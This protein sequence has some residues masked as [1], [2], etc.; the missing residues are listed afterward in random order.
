MGLSSNRRHPRSERRPNF[1]IVVISL[2]TTK[3]ANL[4]VKRGI[5]FVLNDPTM[6]GITISDWK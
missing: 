4:R 2:L 1:E 5:P 6:R 3:R